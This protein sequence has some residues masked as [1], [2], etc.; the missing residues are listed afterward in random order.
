[1]E[2]GGGEPKGFE[3]A[4]PAKPKDDLLAYTGLSVAPI[5]ALGDLP[6]LGAVWLG[7]RVE[8]EE[9]DATDGHLPDK[10]VDISTLDLHGHPCRIA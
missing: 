3:R 7:V 10:R 9:P 4:D 8:E 6:V 5:E 1:V 2:H